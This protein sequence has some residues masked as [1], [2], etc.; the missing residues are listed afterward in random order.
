MYEF[1]YEDMNYDRLYFSLTSSLTW[2][3]RILPS[4]CANY[5]C[6]TSVVCAAE[7]Q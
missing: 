6:V 4:L 2:E 3:V 5:V 1:K 7:L